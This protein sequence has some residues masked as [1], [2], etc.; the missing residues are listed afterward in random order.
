MN[1][2]TLNLDSLAPAFRAR[3]LD[4]V[5]ALAW[6]EGNR[7]LEESKRYPEGGE[8]HRRMTG[9][10]SAALELADSARRFSRESRHISENSRR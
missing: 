10:G 8:G 3:V 2:Y 7:T 1:T 6:E 4:A 5:A 9:W